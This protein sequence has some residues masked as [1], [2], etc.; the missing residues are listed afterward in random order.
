MITKNDFLEIFKKVKS[1][2]SNLDGDNCYLGLQIVAKYSKNIVAGA[3][4]DVLYSE[5]V[6]NLIKQGI[7][8]EDVTELRKLNWSIEEQD[9]LF[10]FV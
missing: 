1:D 9:Y 3:N 7:T 6:E 4:H 2:I 5:S 10:C 8:K